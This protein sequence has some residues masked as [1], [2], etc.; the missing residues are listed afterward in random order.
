MYTYV[1]IYVCMYIHILCA[2]PQEHLAKR[3]AMAINPRTLLCG[4]NILRAIGYR[5]KQVQVA[6]QTYGTLGVG[7]TVSF[8]VAGERVGT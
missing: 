2:W 3:L 8:T 7:R 1:C 4:A 6:G 5:D